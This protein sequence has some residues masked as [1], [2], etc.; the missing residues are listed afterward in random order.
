MSSEIKSITTENDG[1]TKA[2]RVE[3]IENGWLI[4]EN[5]YGQ[6][7]KEGD[8]NRK[9][10]DETKKYYSKENP[11]EV[12]SKEEDKNEV[13]EEKDSPIMI[14]LKNLMNSGVGNLVSTKKY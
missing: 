4:V 5:C 7:G 3:K 2:I 13:E 9:Y 8:K 14:A 6:L 1:M 10:M 12:E 11:L